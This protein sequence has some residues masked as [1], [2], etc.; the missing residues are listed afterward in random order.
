[1]A[2]RYNRSVVYKNT[3]NA[4][5]RY[6]KALIHQGASSGTGKSASI[7][8]FCGPSALAGSGRNFIPENPEIVLFLDFLGC[9]ST[10]GRV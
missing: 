9:M 6:S 1:M 2:S 7:A 8:S 3:G 10:D 5:G 4:S